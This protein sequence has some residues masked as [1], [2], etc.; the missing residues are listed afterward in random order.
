MFDPWVWKF[1]WRK[2]SQPIPVFLPEKFHAQRSLAGYSLQGC[3]ESDTTETLIL[4]RCC[5]CSS[6]LKY[7]LN[8]IVQKNENILECTKPELLLSLFL[9]IYLCPWM[10][11]YFNMQCSGI[12]LYDPYAGI[13]EKRPHEVGWART[14]GR[15][16]LVSSFVLK[17]ISLFNKLL[18]LSNET[19]LYIWA[20]YK[21][22]RE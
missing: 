9:L 15:S 18:P 8:R 11:K 17:Q 22:R 19:E 2:E 3:K 16:W 7:F 1:Y 6:L 13:S 5:F 21:E 4:L 20:L 14:V 12:T 10:T